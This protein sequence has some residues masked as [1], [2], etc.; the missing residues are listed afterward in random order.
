MELNIINNAGDVPFSHILQG[1]LAGTIEKSES[2][3]ALYKSMKG[4]IA[5]NLPDIEAAVTLVF[6]QGRMTMEAGITKNPAIVITTSAA[7]VTDLNMLTVRWGLPY[8]FDEAGRRVIGH[9]FSGRLKIKGLLSH[10][11]LLTRLTILMS[12]M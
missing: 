3:Q 6:Q 2:R 8:Y 4:V 12:V 9:I 7:L 1:L 5:I 11:V 10:P